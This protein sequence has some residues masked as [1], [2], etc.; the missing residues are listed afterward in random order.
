MPEIF[1]RYAWYMSKIC[2]GF[3]WKIPEI[4]LKYAWDMSGICR[5]FAWYM[6]EICL[7]YGWD[8]PE[9]YLRWAWDMPEIGLRYVWDFTMQGECGKNNENIK[10]KT[11]LPDSLT[12]KWLLERLS[13]L[14]RLSL[15]TDA[16]L[17]KE[18]LPTCPIGC[19]EKTKSVPIFYAA[20]DILRF[21]TTKKTKKN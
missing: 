10:Q 21:W 3:T 14:K 4:W 19:P 8:M 15:E 12:K 11:W 7:R 20:Q 5:R 9:I 1:L 17:I 13:P 2:L 6:H 18:K 16:S